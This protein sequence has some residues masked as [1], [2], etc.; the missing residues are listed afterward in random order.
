MRIP[1][2]PW[3]APTVV[4]LGSVASAAAGI[5]GNPDLALG[6]DIIS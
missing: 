3:T 5:A 2:R 4:D 1:S 6:S